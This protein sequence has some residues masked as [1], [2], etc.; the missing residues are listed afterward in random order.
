MNNIYGSGQYPVARGYGNDRVN[1]SAHSY[2]YYRKVK[3]QEL[4]PE[5]YKTLNL[6]I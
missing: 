2:E 5:G 3:T 1:L 6:L 4:N